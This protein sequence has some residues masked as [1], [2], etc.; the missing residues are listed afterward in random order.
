MFRNELVPQKLRFSTAD[1]YINR[2]ILIWEK[3]INHSVDL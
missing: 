3:S 2:F 1:G